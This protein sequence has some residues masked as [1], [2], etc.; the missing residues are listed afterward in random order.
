VPKTGLVVV[1]GWCDRRGYHPD[2]RFCDAR[3]VLGIVF[4]AA[5][6][7][8]DGG[9]VGGGVGFAILG[10]LDDGGFSGSEEGVDGAFELQG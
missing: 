10:G 4:P 7:A 8:E 6:D 9:G 2:L 3:Q 5:D 1:A